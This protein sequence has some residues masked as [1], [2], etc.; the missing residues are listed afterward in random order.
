MYS[1]V[2][3]YVPRGFSAL[4]ASLEVSI[5]PGLPSFSMSGVKEGQRH[6]MENRLRAAL[7]NNGFRWPQGRIIV[8]IAPAWLQKKRLFI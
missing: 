7:K 6:E 4:E 3:T 5:L 8:A 2:K 1:V